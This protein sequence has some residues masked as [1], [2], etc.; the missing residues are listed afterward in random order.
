MLVS[1]AP[2]FA[3]DEAPDRASA[4]DGASSGKGAGSATGGVGLDRLLRVPN[5]HSVAPVRR[6]ARDEES[7]RE[8]FREARSEVAELERK[9][10][11]A[12]SKLRGVAQAN[13]GFSAAG[14]GPQTDPEVMRLRAA[15]RRDR[16]SLRASRDRLRDLTVEASLA[17]VPD[18]WTE[19]PAPP[20]SE[21]TPRSSPG[22]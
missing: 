19:P 17:G 21:A 3:Q 7:W 20:A 10:A 22:R 12:Q 14:G 9:I 4:A 2:V 13:W 5:T 6:G 1:G 11:A 8:T 18:E 15:L 16:Q